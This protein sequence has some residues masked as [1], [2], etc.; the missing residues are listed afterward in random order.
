MRRSWSTAC[1]PPQGEGKCHTRRAQSL[2]RRHDPDRSLQKAWLHRQGGQGQAQR[3]ISG[4]SA[5]PSLRKKTRI[6]GES[7]RALPVSRSTRPPSSEFAARSC[8]RSSSCWSYAPAISA[9]SSGT[10]RLEARASQPGWRDGQPVHGSVECG[11]GRRAFRGDG[12]G[13]AVQR[14]RRNISGRSWP[15]G[16]RERR[17]AHSPV[18][19]LRTCAVRAFALADASGIVACHETGETAHDRFERRRASIVAPPENAPP[20]PGLVLF[21]R[22][23]NERRTAKGE[24][25]LFTHYVVL[26]KRMSP[27]K[28]M[29]T[30]RIHWGVENKLHWPL[31]VV[32]NEDDAQTQK[33][34]R[35]KIFPSS[36]EWLSLS[37]EPILANDPS[38]AK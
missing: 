38:P 11:G 17:P 28:M 8:P 6:K 21:G 20:F 4:D 22:I 33:T 10:Q 26:S 14:T 31:D 34:T 7:A 23:E 37:C 29:A 27:K 3:L 35:R 18:H 15:G 25:A 2:D 30:I 24:P 32:F 19:G 9:V 13:P 1:S 36:D 16:P 5:G 12:P